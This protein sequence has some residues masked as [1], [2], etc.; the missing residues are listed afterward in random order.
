MDSQKNPESGS[1]PR[2]PKKQRSH[3]KPVELLENV[4]GGRGAH[5]AVSVLEPVMSIERTDN[6]ERPEYR[7]VAYFKLQVK[8]HAFEKGYRK[9][10]EKLFDSISLRYLY[11]GCEKHEVKPHADGIAKVKENEETTTSKSL[12][13][14]AEGNPLAGGATP[15]IGVH[16]ARDNKL[17]YERDSKSWRRGLSFESCESTI[18]SWS[19]RTHKN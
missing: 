15:T 16:V 10:N 17:A 18:M 12:D 8:I 13:V 9:K 3:V 5:T 7:I 11:H 1:K 14:G 4:S 19:H 6:K 2:T